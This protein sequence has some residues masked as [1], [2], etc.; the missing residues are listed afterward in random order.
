MDIPN[1]ENS[2]GWH[3]ARRRSSGSGPPRLLCL[4]LGI[5][6]GFYSLLLELAHGISGGGSGRS[7]SIS[8]ELLGL[9]SFHRWR[10][11]NLRGK[12]DSRF[13]RI[14]RLASKDDRGRPVYSWTNQG[15]L[16]YQRQA[17]E[18]STEP[19][20]SRTLRIAGDGMERAAG[21]LVQDHQYY[22]AC[23]WEWTMGSTPFFWNWPTEYQ[24][25]V[26]DGQPQ[27]RVS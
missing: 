22:F 16:S 18:F 21:H 2:G 25:E 26:R 4:L 14:V 8:C 20:T 24:E 1:S 11:E 17:E 9:Q 19:R 27:Y 12:L 10:S 13:P 6:N 7:A 3:R 23:C 15:K 5:D